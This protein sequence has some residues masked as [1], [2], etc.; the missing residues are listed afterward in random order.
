MAR[1]NVKSCQSK[2][3]KRRES[4]FSKP[5]FFFFS[6]IG[7]HFHIPRRMTTKVEFDCAEHDVFCRGRSNHR[8]HVHMPMPRSWHDAWRVTSVLRRRSCAK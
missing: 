1:A 5:F 6:R 4:G 8:G 2:R 7:L 3:Q